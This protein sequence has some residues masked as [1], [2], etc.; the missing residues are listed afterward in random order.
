MTFH[1]KL[2]TTDRRELLSRMAFSSLTLQRLAKK[3]PLLAATSRPLPSMGFLFWIHGLFSRLWTSREF[4]ATPTT[5]RCLRRLCD[6]RLHDRG[7]LPHHPSSGTAV[8]PSRHG[9]RL[10]EIWIR[11]WTDFPDPQRLGP[12]TVQFFGTGGKRGRRRN[13]NGLLSRESRHDRW[14]IETR[15]STRRRYGVERSQGILA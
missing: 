1:V 9:K 6:R 4:G 3:P 5:S 13:L 8:F 14:R 15:Q 12:R 7:R 10:V 11:R 2:M